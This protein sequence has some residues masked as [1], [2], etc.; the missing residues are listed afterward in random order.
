MG[1]VRFYHLTEQPLEAVLPVMLERSLER[2]WRVAVRGTEPA[3]ITSLDTH[4]WTYRDDSFLPHG[5]D[6]SGTGEGQPVWLSCA[7]TLPNDPNTLMLIDGAEAPV[8]QI[9]RMEM[10]AIL[11][12]GLDPAAVEHARTQWRAV[13]G[14]GIKAVYWAQE[15]GRWVKKSE[16]A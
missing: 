14:A 16:S 8:D 13:T 15:G 2:G 10:T 9:S 12:D 7:D 4:L 6:G 5:A 3:R 1:E 11:F